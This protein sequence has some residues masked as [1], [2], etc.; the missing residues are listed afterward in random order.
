MKSEVFGVSLMFTKHTNIIN[1][2][3][4]N[5]CLVAHT[6]YDKISCFAFRKPYKKVR[7]FRGRFR[8]FVKVTSGLRQQVVRPKEAFL[9]FRFYVFMVST[10]GKQ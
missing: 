7:R 5:I 4:L 1:S 2:A 9:D 8:F 6:Y 3:F 10:A